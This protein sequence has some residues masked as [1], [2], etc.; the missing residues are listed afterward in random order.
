MFGFEQYSKATLLL[1]SIAI[2]IPF[3]LT[4]TVIYNLFF[5]PLAKVPGPRFAAATYLYQTYHSVHYYAEVGKM[6][7]KYGPIVRTTPDEVSLSDPTNY[8]LIFFVGSKYPKSKAYDCVGAG[9]STFASKSHDLHRVRRTALNPFFSRKMVLELEDVVQDKARKLCALASRKFST[10]KALDLHHAFRAVSID[11]ITDYAF[12]DCYNLLERD[13]I[14]KEFFE[15]IQRRG[16][17]IWVFQQ[18]PGL[19][20]LAMSMP[21]WLAS[22][23]SPPIAHTLKLIEHCRKQCQSV[24]DAM[25]SGKLTASSRPTIFREL[26]SPDGKDDDYVIPTVDQ[27]KDEAHSILAAAADTTGNAMTV[28]GY[29]TVSNPE[30]FATLKK[31]LEEA[32]PN[33]EQNLSFVELEKLPYLTAVIKEGLRMSF[34]VP[35]RLPREVPPPGATFNGIFIPAGCVVGMS[36]WVLHQDPTY[37]PNPKKFDPSRWLDPKEARRIDK[38]FVPF[39]KGTRAC[40]GMP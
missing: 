35:G 21:K 22:A 40:V 18:W 14:G 12:A 28:A 31:E 15:M 13:D 20:A 39:S 4:W 16:P 26:L 17:A 11:V 27:L 37:F 3:K 10:G 19:R 34:G 38:A 9:Y 6:H 30:I 5:H 36:T 33:A 29:H 8:D 2:Y 23:M 7:E 1:L 24:K 32:F 25:D